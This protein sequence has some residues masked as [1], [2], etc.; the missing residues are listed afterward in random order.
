[1]ILN[2][3]VPSILFLHTRC[4]FWMLDS[5]FSQEARNMWKQE[6]TT[7]QVFRYGII[8]HSTLSFYDLRVTL[9][10]LT[11]L[12]WHILPPAPLR[13][14]FSDPKTLLH[15]SHHCNNCQC[16]INCLVNPSLD[17]LSSPKAHQALGMHF[18][19]LHGFWLHKTWPLNLRFESWLCHLFRHLQTFSV[20]DLILNIFS[21]AV[22]KVSVTTTELYC[23]S[24]KAIS[25]Y[26][27]IVL[28]SNKTLSMEI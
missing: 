27:Q 8:W 15:L 2:L 7:G 24:T 3:Q 19:A 1:M 14:C 4:S 13:W 26:I 20:K 17:N 9:P 12:P 21:L 10:H 28:C 23:C 25:E 11:K 16:G 6:P 18:Q 5:F 22:C